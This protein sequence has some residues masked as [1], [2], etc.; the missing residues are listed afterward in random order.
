MK[1]IFFYILLSSYILL[2]TFFQNERIINAM[3]KLSFWERIQHGCSILGI[4]MSNFY[5]W[6]NRGKVSRDRAI[7]LYEALKGTDSEVSLSE[8]KSTHK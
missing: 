1:Y 8:I 5:V 4:P 6:K 7:S 3:D 2:L